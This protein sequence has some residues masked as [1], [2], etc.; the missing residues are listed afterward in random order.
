MVCVQNRYF[1]G[2]SAEEHAFVDA[3]GKQGIAFV[4]FFSIAGTGR[5]AG[6]SGSEHE[7]VLSAARAHGATAA[8]ARLAWTLQRGPHVLVIPGTGDPAHLA[9]NVAAGALRLTAGEV[10]R[11][12]SLRGSEGDNRLRMAGRVRED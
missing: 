11:L 9:A 2:A 5:G 6:V 12:T 3:C 1:L 4:P 10:A 8:Q 7:E